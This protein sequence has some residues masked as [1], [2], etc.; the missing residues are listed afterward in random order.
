M[1]IPIMILG[2]GTEKGGKPFLVRGKG[3]EQHPIY[4]LFHDPKVR[5]VPGAR[6]WSRFQIASLP[7]PAYSNCLMGQQHRVTVKRKRRKA[8]VERKRAAA[9]APRR[10]AAKSRAKKPAS[11]SAS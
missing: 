2:M 8:Y 3:E 10:P 1:E 6:F 4:E 11:V 9:K 5:W 7:L